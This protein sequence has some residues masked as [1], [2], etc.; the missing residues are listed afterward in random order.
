[1]TV[2][3]PTRALTRHLI[4][5]L[6][7]R[8]L[9]AEVRPV[10]AA[11][12]DPGDHGG[13][14]ARSAQALLEAFTGVSLQDVAPD[15]PI[16]VEVEPSLLDELDVLPAEP[17]R[18]VVQLRLDPSAPPADSPGLARLREM[19][20]GLAVRVDTLDALGVL[21][22]WAG[23]VRLDAEHLS[24]DELAAATS[25]GVAADRAV[26]VVG[27]MDRASAERL[28]RLGCVA[29][30]GD[31]LA[32]AEPLEHPPSPLLGELL[33]PRS[34]LEDLRRAIECDAHLTYRL[35]RHVNSAFF[36]R[37]TQITT[38]RQA[39]TLLGERMLRRW[40]TLVALRGGRDQDGG[41]A[42]LVEALVRARM[43]EAAA[44]AQPLGADPQVA[45]SVGLLSVLPGL[46]GLSLADSVADLHLSPTLDAALVRREAPYGPLLAAVVGHLAGT[47]APG[48]PVPT[49]VLATAFDDALRWMRPLAGEVFGPAPR[50]SVLGG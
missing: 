45:F 2:L 38:V 1:M 21:P 24:L 7:G 14:L 39:T 27:L 34:D 8:I 6:D 16:Y 11:P 10:A 13:G 12:G 26:H 25:V 5:D 29:V 20:Y 36:A 41:H 35:L 49:A 50:R 4:V 46:T 30:Q 15:R 48:A 43:A 18:L 3:S 19:G 31:P 17:T 40:T 22:D 44:T 28:A 37:R 42:L 23:V 9:G 32:L 47:S 33:D